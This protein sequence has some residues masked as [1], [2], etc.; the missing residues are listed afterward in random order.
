MHYSGVAPACRGELETQVVVPF[1]LPHRSSWFQ[2]APDNAY[3]KL[4]SVVDNLTK[5]VPDMHK[6]VTAR[7]KASLGE[8]PS[9]AARYVPEIAS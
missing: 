5:T 3:R 2:L 6:D 1:V 8:V 9:L 4:Q 7:A